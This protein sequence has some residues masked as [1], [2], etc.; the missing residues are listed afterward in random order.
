[1]LGARMRAA[2]RLEWFAEATLQTVRFTDLIPVMY[3]SGFAD[4]TAGA[5][6]AYEFVVAGEH[7]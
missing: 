5:T 4:L 2:R 3:R 1:M 6:L 7:F